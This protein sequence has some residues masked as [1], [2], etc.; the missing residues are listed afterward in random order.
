MAI[1]L[2]MRT[3][4]S[5][6]QFGPYWCSSLPV[7][8]WLSTMKYI[9]SS[10]WHMHCRGC[11]LWFYHWGRMGRAWAFK[12]GRGGGGGETTNSQQ[13]NCIDI[14]LKWV[15]SENKTIHK[16]A[17][18]NYQT[19][20]S[21]LC[22]LILWKFGI[23][24]LLSA[25]TWLERSW[26]TNILKRKR[27]TINEEP[28]EGIISHRSYNYSKETANM[29][30]FPVTFTFIIALLHCVFLNNTWNS[31]IGKFQHSIHFYLLTIDSKAF[32]Y[33]S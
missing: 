32:L 14:I 13:Q 12:G 25:S 28:V 16:K 30:Y 11:H 5:P 10:A 2:R 8:L 26:E 4:I 31:L 33:F 29:D 9:P 23:I 3:T 7:H 1:T 21:N 27:Q 22:I 15:T 19:K 17:T 6:R 24:N 20:P 18:V